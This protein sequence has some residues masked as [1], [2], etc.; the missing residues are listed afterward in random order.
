L[1]SHYLK[2][3]Y[4]ISLSVRQ[5]QRLFHQLGFTIQRPRRRAYEADSIEQ[6]EFKKVLPID[7][8]PNYS[9]MG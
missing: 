8:S 1:L 2:E 9:I 5:C 7:G 6:E 4:A 3:Q